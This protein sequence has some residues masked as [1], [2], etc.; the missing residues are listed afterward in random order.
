MVL[1]EDIEVETHFEKGIGKVEVDRNQIE[2]AIMNLVVNAKDAMPRGGILTLD[3]AE[4]TLGEDH[5]IQGEKA[6]PGSYIQLSIR[7]TGIGMRQDTLDRIF[8]PFF[9]TKGEGRGT[10]LGLSTVYGIVQQAGGTIRVESKFGAG[11]TFIIYLPCA[12]A[13]ADISF[14]DDAS[15]GKPRTTGE[16]ILLV[17]DEVDLRRLTK[18]ILVLEGYH[19]LEPATPEEALGFAQAQELQIDLLL[20]DLVMPRMNGRDLAEAVMALRPGIKVVYMSGYAP[21]HLIPQMGLISELNFLEKPFTHAK[22]LAKLRATL[23]AH[24]A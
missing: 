1:G 7:D 3:L 24:R 17:E 2:Q 16:T 11:T 9:S 4:R 13:A 19:V 23:D 12:D 5:F 6:V 10:G 21:D 8:E 22:L 15:E 18:D 14:V 20:T